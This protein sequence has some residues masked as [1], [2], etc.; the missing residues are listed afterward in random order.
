[1][2]T[3]IHNLI[4]LDESGSMQSSHRRRKKLRSV[5]WNGDVRKEEKKDGKKDEIRQISTMRGISRNL[6][7]QSTSS[8]K[9][10]VSPPT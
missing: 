3:R 10:Q 9:Q 1:M 7:S 5:G 2:K 8:L 4:I 6:E